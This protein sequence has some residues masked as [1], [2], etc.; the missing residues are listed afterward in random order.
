MKCILEKDFLE[1]AEKEF[2]EYVT[3]TQN[4][5]SGGTTHH[6][7]KPAKPTEEKSAK[8]PRHGDTVI[9]ED[10]AH[11]DAMEDDS[12]NADDIL[13]DDYD[14]LS[15]VISD[16][17]SESDGGLN[18]VGDINLTGDILVI[19]TTPRPG[20]I[21]TLP[22]KIPNFADNNGGNDKYPST[23]ESRPFHS[24]DPLSTPT[25]QIGYPANTWP[26]TS[27]QAVLGVP[28]I[29]NYLPV[30]NAKFPFVPYSPNNFFYIPQNNPSVMYCLNCILVQFHVHQLLLYSNYRNIP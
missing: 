16:L 11:H 5:A 28:M 15:G 2:I 6:Q 12:H 29:W 14:E 1:I 19:E 13:T 30:R 25:G 8:P 20:I 21:S 26:L 18:L 27:T 24:S 9:H 3:E 22:T 7:L 4:V 17:D 10:Q 23:A